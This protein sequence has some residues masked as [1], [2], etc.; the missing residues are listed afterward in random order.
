MEKSAKNIIETTSDGSKT[1]YVPELDE[2]Y[3]SVN[4]ALNEAITVF[5]KPG[6]PTI[7]KKEVSILEIGFGTGLN[8]MLTAIEAMA[9]DK[10]VYYYGIEKYPVDPHII[11][12]LDYGKLVDPVHSCL[13]QDIHSC[14]WDELCEINPNFALYKIC[15]DIKVFKSNKK[16]DIIY[17]DAFAKSKQPGMW[18]DEIIKG[19][20]SMAGKGSLFL[21]YSATGQLK[22][23]LISNGF[24]V[25][26]LPG[27]KGKREITRAEMV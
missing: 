23:Q 15:T 18:T 5:I 25:K 7:S 4:G 11:N 12:E 24:Q 17:F 8:A 13:F 9:L 27:P 26:R 1:I 21:T 19:V 6:L 10:R 22:R 2:H 16:F 20:C 3:H 14:R